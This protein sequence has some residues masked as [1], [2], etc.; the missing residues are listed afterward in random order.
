MPQLLS[1]PVLSA[2][3]L[4]VLF[5]ITLSAKVPTVRIA[6]SGGA[7]SAPIET[8]DPAALASIWAGSFIGALSEEPDRE[9]P[10]YRVTFYVRWGTA[11]AETIEP[12]Y[13]VTYARNPR[14]G[15]GFVYLPG[16]SE[17]GYAMNVGSMER[18]G[19]DGRWH[20]ADA[21]WSSAIARVLPPSFTAFSARSSAPRR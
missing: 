8:T 6:I 3:T 18:D 15:R 17:E 4:I 9:L 5:S 11:S 10:R 13:V 16:R 19:H 20:H 12:K 21:G 2:T 14:N 1:S 7:L